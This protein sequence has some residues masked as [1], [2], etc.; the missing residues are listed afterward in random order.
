[1]DADLIDVN[2]STDNNNKNNKDE[3][4]L[5]LNKDY[6]PEHYLLQLEMFDK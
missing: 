3:A 6:L 1:M 5:S 4:W 2:K